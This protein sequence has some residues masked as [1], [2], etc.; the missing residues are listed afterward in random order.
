V[1]YSPEIPGPRLPETKDEWE[2]PVLAARRAD[3]ENAA[4]I[5]PWRD[6][7]DIR[8]EIE[9]VCP[10][11]KG[12]A[13][14]RKKGDNFQYGG[15][16]LLVDRFLTPDGKGHFSAVS[17]PEEHVPPGHFL[18]ATR[19]G[20]QFNSI[21][22]GDKD[23]LNGALRDDILM[24]REDAERLGLS[25]GDAIVLSNDRGEFRGRVKIDRV[26]PGSLQGYWPEV[27]VLVPAGCL[28][29]SGVP[30]YNAAVEVFPADRAPERR[31]AA[32]VPA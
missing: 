9:R 18:L 13:N 22:H 26:K 7:Q 15:A 28:D 24:A 21:I 25:D 11:Y 20:R 6:T 16:R 12:I 27:N 29:A 5:F 4:K 1:I 31:V 14:L 17:L 2:I 23:L 3:P 30:D 32:A 8:D 19:R 10:T